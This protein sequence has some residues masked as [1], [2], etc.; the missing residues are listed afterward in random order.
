M[1]VSKAPIWLC[2][3]YGLISSR[4]SIHFTERILLTPTLKELKE[5]LMEAFP[6]FEGVQKFD[7]VFTSPRSEEADLRDS[8]YFEE[9]F[10]IGQLYGDMLTS[11]RLC[12]SGQLYLGPI[13]SIDRQY[14]DEYDRAVSFSV[15]GNESIAPGLN[16]FEYINNR[17]LSMYNENIF[18]VPYRLYPRDIKLVLNLFE[19]FH[20]S[21]LFNKETAIA[22][23][24]F[25]LS[26]PEDTENKLIDQMIAFE[27]LLIGDDRELGYKLA[28]RTAFLLRKD[29]T[30]IFENMKKAYAL[31]SKIVHGSSFNKANLAEI[32]P[33]TEDY[34]RQS[35][36]RILALLLDGN[37]LKDIREKLLD[38]N[39][40]TSG[41]SLRP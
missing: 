10:K 40:I 8:V 25:N 18:D 23:Y 9:G 3:V 20:K 39:I 36:K 15:L 14:G 24:R 26:Y 21:S 27:S 32:V 37:S 7:F 33:K 13:L 29:M 2:P 5:F 12:H 22:L 35:I 38:K 16:I 17:G 30:T 34:L 31:R 41:R 4:K 11:L 1:S 19:N 28:M 6:F